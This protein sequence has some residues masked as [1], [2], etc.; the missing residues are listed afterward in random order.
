MKLLIAGLAFVLAIPIVAAGAVVDALTAGAPTPVF[1]GDI[2]AL[3]TQVLSDPHIR[4]LANARKD[5]EAG[6]VDGRVLS[7]LLF[8]AA[9]HDLGSVGP[10][11]SGH[12]YFV[13]ET[14]RV[15]NHVYG[16]AVDISVVDGV[17]VSFS[18]AGALE[19][20]RALLSLP[21][22]FRPDEVGSPWDLPDSGSFADDQ[23]STH[24]HFGWKA[25]RL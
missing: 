13:K 23:H 25:K 10:F 6:R 8:V 14:T 11:V 21:A 9:K 18:N 22:P 1:A 16:R 5:V 19:A 15:S 12:S 2:D 20:V 7:A 24:L 4:L 17:A 3:G